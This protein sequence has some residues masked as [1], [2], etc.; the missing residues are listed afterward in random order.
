M[1]DAVVPPAGRPGSTSTALLAIAMALAALPG[2]ASAQTVVD[3]QR[4]AGARGEVSIDNDFG[5]VTVRGWDRAEVAV[6]GTLAAGAE[7]FSFEG[8][9]D[10]TSVSVEVPD[11][12][13]HA[14]GEAPAF[15]STLEVFVP[16][17]SRL[18][19]STTNADI[20]VESVTGSLE[21]STINGAVQVDAPA[22]AVEIETMTG[23]V[24]VRS[25]RGAVD[26]VSISGDVTVEGA[27][28]GVQVETVSGAVTVHGAG[29]SSL[30]VETTTGAVLIGGSFAARGE[31]DVES[32]SGPVRLTLPADLRASFDLR[33]FSGEITSHLCAG[34]PLRRDGF[35]PFRQLRCSTGGDALELSIRTHDGDITLAPAGAG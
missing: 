35:E 6:K 22:A 20:T 28:G 25:P 16:V 7:G 24:V 29:M 13:L 4:A 26:V 18:S 1:P 21:I 15:R 32:F 17:G 5:S 19:L 34:T 33:T 11:E 27:A 9:K 10:E 23:A 14:S 30:S 2:A 12:W 8:E 31:I 3:R